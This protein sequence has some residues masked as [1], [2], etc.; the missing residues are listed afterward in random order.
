M[1]SRKSPIP[2]VRGFRIATN[3]S[4]KKA[5][6]IEKSKCK[7]YEKAYE[8]LIGFFKPISQPTDSLD[9][10]AQHREKEQSCESFMNTSPIDSRIKLGEEKFI[11]FVEI[12]ENTKLN[13]NDLIDYCQRYFAKDPVKLFHKKITIEKEDKNYYGMID[14][15]KLKL[16]SRSESR[17]TQIDVKSLHK[18][19]Y[20]V[21]PDDAFCM[22]GLTEYDLFEDDSDLFIAGL[23]APIRRVAAFSYFRYNPRIS[24]SEFDWF[25]VRNKKS[26]SK[27]DYTVLL[28][29]ACRL[30]VHETCHLLG[31]GHCVYLNCCMNGSGHIKEDFSQSHFLCP[32]DL[33]KMQAIFKFNLSEYYWGLKEFFDKHRQNSESKWLGSV[34][35]SL[36]GKTN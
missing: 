20:K 17:H 6:K 32:V 8:N 30:M 34:I 36:E 23:V 9:W 11:Y 21:M 33:K 7:R 13:F 22:I 12:G 26:S 5:L 14:D 16:K 25:S 4:I 29:R 19:L 2:F 24:Y 1:P 18:V 10:L 3:D 28:L 15:V 27:N 31:V 35:E